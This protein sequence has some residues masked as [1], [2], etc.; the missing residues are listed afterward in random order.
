[1]GKAVFA[2]RNIG[3][4]LCLVGD[5][6]GVLVLSPLTTASAS[7]ETVV[8]LTFDDGLA[9]QAVALPL[10]ASHGM[11]A[12]FFVN[13]GS[14]D[15]A[16][17]MSWADLSD[18]QS[19]GHEVGGHTIVHVSLPAL[20]DEEKQHQVCD[21]R[22]AL[23]AH[24]LVA[25]SF[26]YPFG[27]YD[28]TTGPIIEGCGYS[29]ARTV[30]AVG[31]NSCTHAAETIP[32]VE[33]FATRTIDSVFHTTTVEQLQNYV[34]HAEDTGGGWVQFVFHH[35]CDECHPYSITEQNL[36]DFLDWL[37]LRETSG[38]VV[39][40]VRSVIEPPPPPPPFDQPSAASSLQVAL[41][42]N[43]RQTISSLQCVA[44]GGVPSAHGE[45][46]AF[47]ACDP[48]AIQLGA[49][50]QFGPA[51]QG[52]ATLTV[53]PGDLSTTAD[54]ADVAV[55]ASLTDVQAAGDDYAPS[56]TEP[57]AELRVSW[58]LSD[59]F[60]GPSVSDPG[61]V[62]DLTFRAALDCAPTPDPTTGSICSVNSSADGLVPGTIGEG[63][64]SVVQASRVRLADAG[65]N[66]ALGDSDDK[67]FAQ[68]GV[69]VP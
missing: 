35:V 13:S 24:G 47:E 38:T 69:Y 1:M 50:A 33:P 55:T 23:V 16:G 43:F 6:A 61:T 8:S 58:R 28:E 42:P 44:R 30:G 49:V 65:A 57:D 22:A 5:L 40:T 60:N 62:E 4:F 2:L 66:G 14:V 9:D 46:L 67:D 32:P 3:Q 41:V 51:A 56:A 29:S 36:S 64:G 63:G 37:A 27:E 20:S 15:S 21:D 31:C 59:S 68:Q 12:T 48:P 25:K 52:A 26:A 39:K 54:E 10:L 53:V 45:P 7:A 17:Y 11:P 18:L 34:T 19:S